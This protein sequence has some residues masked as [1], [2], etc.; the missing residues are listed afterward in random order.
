M[1][2]SEILSGK[3]N[4]SNSF[5]ETSNN[6]ISEL[7]CELLEIANSGETVLDLGSGTGNFLANVYKKN[8]KS[9]AGIIKIDRN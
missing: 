1:L 9:I 5:I 2:I 7:A 3:S 6:Y 8:R 4:S